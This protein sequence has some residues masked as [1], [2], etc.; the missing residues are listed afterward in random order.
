[1]VK[2]R[3]GCFFSTS[4]FIFGNHDIQ[5]VVKERNIGKCLSCGSRNVNLVERCDQYK[6]FGFIPT[7]KNNDRVAKC[8]CC[9]REIREVHFPRES[10]DGA[11]ENIVGR[12]KTHLGMK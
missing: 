5:Y 1:M 2:N 8:N 3:R 7:P 12:V 10:N 11:M 9:G 4:M 6:V